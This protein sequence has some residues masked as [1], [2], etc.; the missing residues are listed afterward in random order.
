MAKLSLNE[1]LDRVLQAIL[2]PG[3]ALGGRDGGALGPKIAALAAVAQQLRGLPRSDFKKRLKTE[4]ER[5]ESMAGKPAAIPG[6]SKDGWETQESRQRETA[7]R[8][9]YIRQ[10]YRTITP[11]LTVADAEQLI[12]FMKRTFDAEE[13]FRGTGGAGGIHCELRVGNSMVMV[14]GGRPGSSWSGATSPTALHVYVS[15]CVAAYERALRAGA[16]SMMEPAEQQYGEQLAAVRDLA[17]NE[18]YIAFPTY[19]GDPHYRPDRVQT[20][21]AYL[22]PVKSVPVIEFL[23]QAFSAEELGRAASPEGAILHTTVRIGDSTLEMSDAHGPYQPMPTMFYLYVDDTDSF[24]MRA[25]KAGASSISEPADMPYGDRVGA[26]NDAFGN[27]WYIAMY[28]GD[29]KTESPAAAEAENSSAPAKYIREGFHTLTPYLLASDG[30][31]LIDFLKQAFGA[32]EH[33]RVAPAGG[34]IMHAE[35][36]I[37]DSMLELSDGTAEFPPRA[38]MYIL[39]VDDV[40]ATYRRALAAGGTSIFEPVEQHYGEREAGVKDTDGNAWYIT[41][42]RAAAHITPDTRTIVPGFSMHGVAKFVEFTRQA[43]AAEQAFINKSSSG[44]VI[45]GRIRIGDSIIA[46]GEAHGKSQPVPFHLHMY[47]PD[48]DAVYQS[49][50]RAG[51]KSLRPPK[52]EPYGDRAA[53]VE[54]AFGNYWSFATHIKDVKF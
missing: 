36:R 15:D 46:V 37:G 19:L 10:G 31:R 25:L 44:T 38:A 53:T 49:A 13:V 32:D 26:V 21:Q 33:F 11:Y 22:H 54:D 43:F 45:H 40:D 29:A 47:V 1:Q 4:L 17:G 9:S 18:W 6:Q 16:T 52:D 23:K 35:L 28:S 34:K 8:P 5:S 27:Q 41:E 48:T 39:Y 7:A 3:A 24:Y 20:V 14:G 12:D 50:L 51:A 2:E 42:R 30:A